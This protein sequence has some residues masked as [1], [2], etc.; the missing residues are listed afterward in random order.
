MFRAETDIFHPSLVSHN[1]DF[2]LSFLWALSRYLKKWT[3][4]CMK[5]IITA[6]P[7]S[8]SA[9]RRVG[10]RVASSNIIILWMLTHN[11]LRNYEQDER[12][13]ALDYHNIWAVFSFLFVCLVFWVR[14]FVRVLITSHIFKASRIKSIHINLGSERGD[15]IFYIFLMTTSLRFKYILFHSVSSIFKDYLLH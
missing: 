9:L 13:Q 10:R 11:N 14:H 7:F 8:V 2:L 5:V 4:S 3:F 6:T 15:N 1:A 12:D